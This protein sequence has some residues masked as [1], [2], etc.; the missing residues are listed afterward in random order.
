MMICSD[1]ECKEADEMNIAVEFE[2][3]VNLNLFSFEI[4]TSI[5]LIIPDQLS[6]K[7]IRRLS[8]NYSE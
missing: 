8:L 1:F 3:L 7:D 5:P 2:K 6:F 4:E